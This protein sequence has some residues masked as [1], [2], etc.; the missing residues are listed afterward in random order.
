ML[1]WLH[2][3]NDER[4]GAPPKAW[5]QVLGGVLLCLALSIAYL[6]WP[7]CQPIPD[8]AAFET[9]HSLEERAA[10]GDPFEKKGG[11]WHQCK[12]RLARAFF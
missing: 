6:L 8:E 2:V 9:V 1:S 10:S 11:R 12:T 5:R 4:S 7:V 3:S